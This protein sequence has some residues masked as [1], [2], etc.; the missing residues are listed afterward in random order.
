MIWGID[1]VQVIQDTVLDPSIGS[2]FALLVF[3][4]LTELVG[5]VPSLI[6]L[7]GQLAFLE[8]TLTIAIIAK[9]FFFVAVPIG[10]GTTLGS[11]IIFTIAYYGGR[12]AIEKFGKYIRLKWKHVEKIESR[13]EGTY[14][15]E[16]LFFALRA[17]PFVPTMP[18]TA[19]AGIFRMRLAPY[20]ILTVVGIMVRTM[21]LF[22]V[23]GL[24]VQ[25]IM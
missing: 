14:Y 9:L 16:I 7:S 19:A 20:L 6:V 25:S 18:V 5:V 11:S 17:M 21:L 4:V 23:V 3:A 22:T 12:P 13:F 8:G 10:I 15:D 2:A 1:A 24:G